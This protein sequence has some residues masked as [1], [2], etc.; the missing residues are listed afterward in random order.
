MGGDLAPEAMN[1]TDHSSHT[2]DQQPDRSSAWEGGDP[3]FVLIEDIRPP[4][5]VE[6]ARERM[7]MSRLY[8]GLIRSLNDDYGAQFVTHSDSSTLR[9]IGIYVFLRTVTCSPVPAGRIAHALKLPRV[10]VL[11]RLQELMKHGYV[12]RVGNA[13]RMTDKMNIPDLERKLDRRIEMI[14]ETARKLSE[15]RSSLDAH[16]S[17]QPAT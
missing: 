10:T 11:R 9:T 13:Y 17:E 16:L 7:L 6:M 12:E 2:R 4:R 1:R 3:D 8:L 14:I 5:R 15:V